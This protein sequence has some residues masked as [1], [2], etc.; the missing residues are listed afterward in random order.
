[1]RNFVIFSLTYIFIFSGYYL[2]TSFLNILYPNYAFISFAIF[3]AV[4]GLGSLFAGYIIEKIG[5]KPLLFLSCIT[6]CIFVG[7]TGSNIVSLLLIGSFIAGLGNAIVWLIQGVF[8]EDKEMA[9]FYMLFNVNIVLGNLLG[10]SILLIGLS[11]QIMILS[12]L[13]LTGLGSLLALCVRQEKEK[14][15]NKVKLKNVFLSAN[16]MIPC[17]IYQAVGLNVTYQIIPRLLKDPIFNTITFIVYGVF[18][19]G[20][21]W[22]WGKLFLKSWKYVVIP[23]SILEILCLAGILLLE[24]TRRRYEYWIIIGAIRGVID[25]GINNTINITL[26]RSEDTSSSFSLYRFIYAISYLLCSICIG[27]ISY[28]YILL[29]CLLCL[30]GS[31]FSYFLFFRMEEVDILYDINKAFESSSIPIS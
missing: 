30:F 8:L 20:F 2:T 21:S 9:N 7:F 18:A 10:M 28:E 14:I 27:Y 29:I 5:F 1:M 3:Y 12:M 31:S 22:I 19:I 16:L 24:K 15:Q 23:Y 13:V 26:A 6:F 4:Y 17:Y 25:Y 11:S